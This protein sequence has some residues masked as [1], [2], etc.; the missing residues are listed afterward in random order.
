M[1]SF[2]GG[3]LSGVSLKHWGARWRT[4]TLHSRKKLRNTWSS[5]LIIGCQTNGRVYG[6]IVYQPLLSASMWVFF[7]FAWCIGIVVHY[8]VAQSCLILCD[9][10]NCSM[11][12][13]P[14]RHC[15]S[16]FAQT[17]VQSALH[18]W[19]PKHQCQSFQWISRVLGLTGLISLSKGPKILLQYHFESI[20]CS[21]SLGAYL[22]GNHSIYSYRFGLAVEGGEFRNF[23]HLVPLTRTPTA[24]LKNFIHVYGLILDSENREE[25]QDEIPSITVIKLRRK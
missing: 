9:P 12:G 6:E 24:F 1:F 17:H 7:L 20:N 15:L 23:L 4:Q 18:I 2:G 5:L 16:E 19:C 25:T 14:V 3:D 10:L 21:S 8:S 11:S 13:F 22:T